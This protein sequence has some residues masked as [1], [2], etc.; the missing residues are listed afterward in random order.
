MSAY[1]VD[2]SVAV[3]WYV[4]E[5]VRSDAAVRL[6]ESGNELHVPD[7]L[8]AET[9]DILWKKSRRREISSGEAKR[10]A[11]ALLAVPL[12]V[13]ATAPLLDGAMEIAT[14]SDRSVYDALYVALAVALGIPFVTAD[15]RLA[16]ALEKSPFGRHI[17]CLDDLPG[18]A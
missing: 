4:T 8:M 2:A 10:I 1:V 9:G 6:L 18:V 3:K 15:R 11:R 12:I 17:V 7:L 14:R 5:E 13:H 16:N